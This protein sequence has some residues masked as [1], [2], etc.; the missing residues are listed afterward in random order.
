MRRLG[1]KIA[2]KRLAEQ[3]RRADGAVE[4]R[5]RRPIERGRARRRTIG[6]PLMVKAT[7]GGGGR[8]IRRVDDDR[9][10]RRGLRSAR[11]EALKAFGDATVFLEQRLTGARHVEVQVVA[12]AHGTVWALGVRDCSMQRRNQKVI[13]ESRRRR[14]DADQ[15]RDLRAA[16]GRLARPRRATRTPAPSSS[17]TSRPSGGSAFLEVNTRLQVE[18]PVT[19][20]TTGVDIVKL[21]LHVAVGAGWIGEPPPTVRA[22]HR[23]PAQR[24]GPQHDFAPA[25]GPSSTLALPVGPGIRVD[26]GVAEGDVIP[27]QYDSMIAKV[28]AWGRDRDEAR[29]RLARATLA[30]RRWSSGAA[31]PTR[32]SCSTCSQRPEVTPARSTRRGSTG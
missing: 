4:R 13:E 20:L 22:R 1:D 28:I 6:Y 19:E 5:P 17:S 30:D 29:A 9:G 24:R 10:A 23:G 26:T 32:R 7:A 12:D 11:A 31:P 2:A 3:R 15:D 21:Q 8:G 25:P 14:A 27:P 16:A 18:H